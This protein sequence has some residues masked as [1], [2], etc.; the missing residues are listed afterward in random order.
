MVIEVF[1]WASG[2]PSNS[3]RMSPRCVTGTPDL[4]DLAA[5]EL[6]VGS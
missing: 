6:V 3:A 4:A 1:I 5:G 2:M